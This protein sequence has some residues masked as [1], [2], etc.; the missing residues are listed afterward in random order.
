M[1]FETTFGTRTKVERGPLE[2]GTRG[3]RMLVLADLSGRASRGACEGSEAL[4]ERPLVPVDVD[5]LDSV[6]RS[7]APR[8]DILIG[9]PPAQVSIEFREFDDFHPDGLRSRL[10]MFEAFRESRA[11]LLDNARFA[12]EA[13]RLTG[14][15]RPAEAQPAE[16]MSGTL[17]RLLGKPP[18]A[19]P[20]QHRVGGVTVDLSSLIEN[21]VRPHIVAGRSAEQDVLL[22]SVAQ[23]EA[24]QLRKVLH[25]PPFQNL[26]AAWRSVAR[27]VNAAEEGGPTILL[28]DVSEEEVRNDLARAGSPERSGLF[29]LIVESETAGAEAPWSLLVGDLGFGADAADV[30]C[31]SALGALAQ[32]AGAPFLA[33]ARPSLF[34]CP[35][36]DRRVD[37]TAWAPSAE[38]AARWQVFRKTSA[39]Q[40]IGLAGPRILMRLPYGE[41]TDPVDDDPPFEEVGRDWNH[42]C[43]LWGNP[44]FACATLVLAGRELDLDDLPAHFHERAMQPAAEALIG[45]RAAERMLSH[46]PMPW[47]SYKDRPAARLLRFQSV[48]DPAT[49]LPGI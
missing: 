36:F 37:P 25:S 40:W 28:L 14:P 13:K 9:D 33:A 10:P 8:I 20:A 41:L 30:E 42:E 11:R 48:A 2:T 4:L 24:D 43:Y 6:L 38:D 34:G 39:A 31:L 23:A 45:E 44:A 32:E 1:E 12:E 5:S 26:E 17:E 27:L 47:M 49:S 19:A 22:D 35:G 3:R 7:Y 21:A 18:G 29:R 15:A 46:G 16:D